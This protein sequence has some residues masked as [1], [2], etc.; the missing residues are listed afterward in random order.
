[1]SFI[2]HQE[3]ALTFLTSPLLSGCPAVS[4][5]F[6]TRTGGVSAAPWDT[7][8]LG[9]GRGDDLSAVQENYR[10]FC[11]CIGTDS[12][13][14][15]LSKQ[16]HETTVRTVTAADAGKG[17][18]ADRDYTADALITNEPNLPL[19]VFS[20]D[21][22]IL[23]LYDPQ[24]GCIGAVHAG[25][26]GCAA[27]IVE[28]TVAELVRVY[29]A[30]PER[31]LAAIGPCIGACCFETDGDVPAAMRAALGAAAEPYFTLRGAK[32]HVDLAGL[33]RAWLIRAGLIAEHISVC[34]LC[35]A[36]HPELFWSHRKMGN[37]RGAQI[38][39]I[40]LNP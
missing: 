24:A 17:L 23:L 37:A 33:N 14:A 29:G 18:Y 22:G 34:G 20:A 16:I 12:R 19:T 4:H 15:V 32:Y 5:G 11:G 10:R 26:R 31:L 27:G 40:A 13:R 9:V 7:L 36:C 2:T 3:G 30:S 28:K 25:W 6:S 39:M 8:N 38:A 35:T 21:C 1:M